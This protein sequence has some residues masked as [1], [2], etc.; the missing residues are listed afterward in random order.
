MTYKIVTLDCNGDVETII[1]NDNMVQDLLPCQQ[2]D[3]NGQRILCEGECA[4]ET[5]EERENCGATVPCLVW[6]D[7][8]NHR[9]H[10]LDGIEAGDLTHLWTD[11]EAEAILAEYAQARFSPENGGLDHSISEGRFYFSR[12]RWQGTIGM[13]TIYLAAR[14][15]GEDEERTPIMGPT[16]A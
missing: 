14:P 5:E 16:D 3:R 13:A 6:H 1:V 8:Q 7:G 10:P 15:G 9:T 4:G 12:S 2:Y 11:A